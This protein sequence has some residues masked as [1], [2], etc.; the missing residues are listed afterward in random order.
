MPFGT[1]LARTLGVRVPWVRPWLAYPQEVFEERDD[2]GK[3][4]LP[5]LGLEEMADKR[6]EEDGRGHRMAVRVRRGGKR[7]S[8]DVVVH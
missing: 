5:A 1:G 4:E 8:L 6:R 3:V 2:V 7:V